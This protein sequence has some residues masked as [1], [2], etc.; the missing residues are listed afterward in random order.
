MELYQNI[1]KNNIKASSVSFN[2]YYMELN[3]E[4]GIK[5]LVGTDKSITKSL[6]YVLNLIRQLNVEG[7]NIKKI[8]LRYDKVI[9]EY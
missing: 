8:D 9:V 5:L 7:R 6:E 2:S 1:E 3:L 4:S